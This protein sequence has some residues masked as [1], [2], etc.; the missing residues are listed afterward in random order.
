MH[1]LI[2]LNR[3]SAG[4]SV[5][6]KMSNLMI[7]NVVEK[8]VINSTL[9]KVTYVIHIDISTQGFHTKEMEPPGRFSGIF[10][11]IIRTH[12]PFLFDPFQENK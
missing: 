9:F 3:L 1:R 10:I 11:P 12:F 7:L 4:I 5:S 6:F 8:K 2:S